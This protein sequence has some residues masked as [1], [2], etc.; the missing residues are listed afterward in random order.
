M[1]RIERVIPNYEVPLYLSCR[2]CKFESQCKDPKQDYP[3][4]PKF[5]IKKFFYCKELGQQ[6]WHQI[7]AYR[8]YN[9]TQQRCK[10]CPVGEAM[11]ELVHAMDIVIP[12][13]GREWEDMKDE[14][15]RR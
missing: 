7:C 8:Y 12:D 1:P 13:R 14:N 15:E 6:V 4:H 11:V 2:F 5:L 3:T 9:N 10:S